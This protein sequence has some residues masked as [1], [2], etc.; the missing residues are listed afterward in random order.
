MNDLVTRAA[1]LHDPAEGLAGVRELRAHLDQL[2]AIHVENALREGATWRHVADALGRSKQAAHRK[3]AQMMRERVPRA[4]GARLAL[5]LARQEA[6]AMR[7]P[8]VG[9]EHVLLGL[10]RLEDTPCAARLAAAGA[11]PAATRAAVRS[12]VPEPTTER[13]N[14]RAA[15][16]IPCR[17]ALQSALELAEEPRPEHVLRALLADPTYGARRA[18]ERLQIDV[19]ALR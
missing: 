19:S 16:T 3:Y 17:A 10:T 8:A 12:V 1:A 2:E 18:L 4:A 7:R 14:G 9:T 6:A 11:T 5:L 13:S 15:L